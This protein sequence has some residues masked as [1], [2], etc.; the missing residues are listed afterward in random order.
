MTGKLPVVYWDSCVFIAWLMNESRVSEEMEGLRQ[1]VSLFDNNRIILLT[2]TLIRTEILA[3]TLSSETK[4]KFAQLFKRQN[5]QETAINQRVSSLAHDIRNFYKTASPSISIKTPDALHLA[6]A[7]H[8]QAEEFHTFDGS[9]NRGLLRLGNSVA[10][11][12]LV[13][14]KPRAIQATLSFTDHQT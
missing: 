2:S 12:P 1:V 3:C 4:E 8:Y 7:I 10:N 9:G 13:I 6:T 11:Y 5:F 14:C